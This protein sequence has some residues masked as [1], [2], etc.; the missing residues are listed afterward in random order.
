MPTLDHVLENQMVGV[1]STM[2]SYI[3]EMSSILDQFQLQKQVKK[4]P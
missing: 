4:K 1:R 2:S 3:H